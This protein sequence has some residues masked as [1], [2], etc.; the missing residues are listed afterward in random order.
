M[1]QCKL[2]FASCPKQ[3]SGKQTGEAAILT[4]ATTAVTFPLLQ[5]GL[6]FC[7]TGDIPWHI[8]TVV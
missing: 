4:F 1:S 7:K 5:Q 2:T 6:S 8:M 3:T